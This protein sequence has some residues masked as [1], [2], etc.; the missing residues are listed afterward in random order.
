VFSG[1]LA[2]Q[3]EATARIRRLLSKE[4]NPPIEQVIRAGLVPLFVDFLK[5]QDQQLQVIL[6]TYSPYLLGL[7][8][9]LV[10]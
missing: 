9:L 3:I 4:D 2:Q 5:S 6:I 7:I 8:R 1:D 10:P